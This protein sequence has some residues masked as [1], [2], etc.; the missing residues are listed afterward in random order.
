[1]LSI[2]LETIVM[3]SLALILGLAAIAA[4]VFLVH[5]LK[6]GIEDVLD[7]LLDNGKYDDD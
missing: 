1:M 2:V 3:G 6:L 5:S 7:K 4:F